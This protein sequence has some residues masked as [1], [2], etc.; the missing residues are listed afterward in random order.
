[1][2]DHHAILPTLEAVDCDISTLPSGEATVL[3]M[4]K[5]R[6]IC[7][8]GEKYRYLE[9][10]VV[11][12]YGGAEFKAKGKVVLQNG[13]KDFSGNVKESEPD[14]DSKALP[15]IAE[16]MTFQAN[17]AVKEGFTSPPKHHT[18]DTI[19][20]SME[21]AGADDMPEEAERKGL[22]T[23]ATRAAILEKLVKAG[24]AE[25]SKKNLLPTVKGKNLIQVLPT[26]LTSAK[27]TA[28]W[29]DKLLQ[30]QHG[31]LS[32][33]EFMNGISAFMKSIVLSNTAPKPEFVA[34][35]P[36]SKKKNPTL[37]KCPRCGLDV[38]EGVK[39]FFCD[40]RDCGFKLWKESKFWTAKRK[41]LTAEIVQRLLEDGYV[42]LK[43][44]YSEKKDKT[45]SAVVSLDDDGGQ[46]VNYKME[47]SKSRGYKK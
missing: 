37:G 22:G 11:A 15:Q 40:G 34:L 13:W 7:A 18:E 8:V 36:D 3:E 46:F 41:K 28:E 30:V 26:S 2:T 5:T 27:L 29:E 32:E 17:G 47:F 23:P 35:F 12:V 14:D 4:L 19:L 21:N 6:L 16:G 20:S 24:L 42:A 31:E 45:Y 43:D 33:T 38:R 9:T 1:V 39:G 25:R 44:L 10:A